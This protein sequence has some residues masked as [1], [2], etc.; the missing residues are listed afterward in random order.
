MTKIL[1]KYLT[2]SNCNRKLRYSLKLTFLSRFLLAQNYIIEKKKTKTTRRTWFYLRRVYKQNWYRTPKS[3]TT[4]SSL[5]SRICE[6][7]ETDLLSFFCMYAIVFCINAN[8][9][10]SLQ[11]KD[12]DI[13]IFF[14]FG[15]V[16]MWPKQ[17]LLNLFL[18]FLNYKINL[19]IN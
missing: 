15:N 16:L 8:G 6:K 7:S 13:Y 12:F 17:L 14:A 1:I 3:L 19:S 9:F 18:L 11:I 4:P 5:T 2:F 10:V